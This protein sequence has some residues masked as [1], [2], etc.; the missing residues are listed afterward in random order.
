MRAPNSSR[1]CPA[2]GDRDRTSIASDGR[3]HSAFFGR[4]KGN[5][6][7]AA[8]D[9]ADRRRCCRGSRSISPPRAADLEALFP[10]R[11]KRS[12]SRSASAAASIWSR[13]PRASRHRLHRLRAVRQRHG[14]DAGA[15]RGD[16]NRQ[17][18]APCRRCHRAAAWLPAASLDGIDLLYPDPWPKRR[19][20]K[21]R[22]VQD[23]SCDARARLA[24]GGDF[25]SPPTLPIMRTGHSSASARAP[26]VRL[27]RRARRRL[28]KAVA[29]FPAPATRRR[30]SAKAARRVIW[31][32]AV[33]EA[34]V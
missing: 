10:P 18:P 28:A 6:A 20:W 4:R 22:F 17:H 34:A 19:H 33:H 3:R 29:G 15:D 32:F 5:R 7:A 1:N 24:A 25:A 2:C 31:C 12:G 27:D 9:G 26:R 13:W 16:R 8:S 11:P 30:R 21:R 23:D 14:Q